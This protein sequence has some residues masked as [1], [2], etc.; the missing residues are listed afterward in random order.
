MQ[1]ISDLQLANLAK[2]R[3]IYGCGSNLIQDIKDPKIDYMLVTE[4]IYI[5]IYLINPIVTMGEGGGGL[6]PGCLHWKHQE[7]PIEL[8][9]S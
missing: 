5:Y 7:V 6:S 8:R 1:G 3:I 4:Y 2:S 9:G